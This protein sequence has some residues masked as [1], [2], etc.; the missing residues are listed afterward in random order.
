MTTEST[1]RFLSADERR[2]IDE[3]VAEAERHT[4]GEI[5]VMVAPSSGRY[6][7]A[8]LIGAVAL[9]F[10]LALGTTPFLGS[11]F[12]VGPQNLWVF[13]GLFVPLWIVLHEAV[14]RVSGLRRL[15][16]SRREMDAEVREAAAVHFFRHGLYRTHE[17]TGVLI[18][19][20]V[21]ERMVWVLGDRGIDRQ[22]GSEFWPAIVADIVSGIR[23]KR[24]ADAICR[25][26]GTIGGLLRDKFPVRPD[27][28]DELENVIME[29]SNN[30]RTQ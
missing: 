23:E 16:A 11:Y 15:F 1:E 8:A 6:P 12:W 19:I 29:P 4:S 9:A 27:D 17:E 21:F 25:A 20:S 5:V 22:I 13:L 2:R 7:S 26:V 18:Y 24:A 10:P 14:K 30:E 28:R 3:C